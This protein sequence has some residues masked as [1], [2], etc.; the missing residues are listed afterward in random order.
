[1]R[2]ACV[3][4]WM[5]CVAMMGCQ[6][7]G[8]QPTA[9]ARDTATTPSPEEFGAWP[10]ATATPLSVTQELWVLCRA[11][12]AGEV[13]ALRAQMREEHGPH[14]DY[15]VVVRVSPDAMDTF[16]KG[17]PMPTGSIVVK[18]KYVNPDPASMPDKNSP[19]ELSEYAWMAKRAGGWE[20]GYADA[21]GKP[22]A[23]Q[24]PP[25]ASCHAR[26]KESDYL[27]RGYLNGDR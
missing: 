25:C 24:L 13:E 3:G 10:S 15:Q 27:F 1:M 22:I 7:G 5:V 4:V 23:G 14:A 16:Q 20:Y 17:D 11:P 18:E 26:A 21:S 12:M 2:A 6:S 9:V 8:S 19:R